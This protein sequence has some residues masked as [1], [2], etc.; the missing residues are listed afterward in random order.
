MVLSGE[1][2]R[3][4][5]NHSSG[6]G[7]G[8]IS[9]GLRRKRKVG[10]FCD[11]YGNGSELGWAVAVEL[12]AGQTVESV[13]EYYPKAVA[14]E[15]AFEDFLPP[16]YPFSIDSEM[17]AK[18]KTIFNQ[19]CAK[20]HGEYQKDENGYPI[21]EPPQFVNWKHVK[22]D[23]DRLE[24]NNEEF[25]SR[26][27]SNPLSDILFRNLKQEGFLLHGSKGLVTISLSS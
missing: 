19:T 7:Q 15:K 21:Y 17:A 23:Y 12:A 25:N 24:G 2:R 13:R 4:A 26:V 14:A 16:K 27:D 1:R 11:G 18:G 9:L 10:Q 6:S 20:C 8:A 5:G 3:V 22:T